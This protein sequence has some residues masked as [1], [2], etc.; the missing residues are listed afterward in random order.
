ML[1][2]TRFLLPRLH[3]DSLDAAQSIRDLKDMLKVLPTKRHEVYEESM[4]RI[5]AQSE[6]DKDL[7]QQALALISHAFGSLTIGQ[8]QH[9]I[10]VKPQD[11]AFDSDGIT[12]HNRFVKVCAGLVE[13][14]SAI[15]GFVHDTVQMFFEHTNEEWFRQADKYITEKC[16]SYLSL[17]DF[18]EASELSELSARESKYPFLRYSALNFGKH[19]TRCSDSDPKVEKMCV[20]FIQPGHLRPMPVGSFQM[21]ATRVLRF[22]TPDRLKWLYYPPLHMAVLCGLVRVV[23]SLIEKGVNVEERGHKWETALHIAARSL[24][25]DMV[26]VLL[27]RGAKIDAINFAGKSA[28]DMVMVEPYENLLTTAMVVSIF[29]SFRKIS[30]AATYHGQLL[31]KQDLRS[32]M[33]ALRIMLVHDPR[34]SPA[35]TN[36]LHD[37]SWL[38]RLILAKGLVANITQEAEEVV[39]LLI[40]HGADVNSQ[41]YPQTSSLQLAALYE[42]PL[43]A[44]RLLAK[45]ANSFLRRE[46]NMTA[47]DIAKARGN[48]VLADL[49]DKNMKSRERQEA[50]ISDL[51]V[52]LGMP[53]SLSS[54][55]ML[56]TDEEVYRAPPRL[57]IS[58]NEQIVGKHAVRDAT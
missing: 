29:E 12:E 46:A 2:T 50:E 42:R 38:F 31:R 36:P 14:Q 39:N 25:K 24:S 57:M 5:K 58:R 16:I 47:L 40:E 32:S 23:E 9:A 13:I 1:R 4:D 37:Q 48:Q 21:I 6:Q 28:L 34:E 22:V 7:A 10:A 41:S 44:Q 54:V 55:T 17:T 15:I 8:L 33:D 11:H 35:G 52:K 53:V 26:Q 20:E 43:I 56:L 27:K 51:A 18:A 45:G 3:L 30:S 19:A 49:L